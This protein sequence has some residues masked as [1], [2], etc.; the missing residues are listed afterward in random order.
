MIKQTICVLS[1]LVNATS[2]FA[3]DFET[4]HLVSLF[5]DSEMLSK[6]QYQSTILL[7]EN[8]NLSLVSSHYV[9]ET[10]DVRGRVAGETSRHGQ[11]EG[12][13]CTVL[14]ASIKDVFMLSC[15]ISQ[16]WRTWADRSYI[17][18]GINLDGE[19]ML[20]L[21]DNQLQCD[22]DK[23]SRATLGSSIKTVILGPYLYFVVKTTFVKNSG[24]SLVNSDTWF[25][26][27]RYSTYLVFQKE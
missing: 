13:S 15:K 17:E 18:T 23:L 1:L 20:H 11:S 16:E 8:Q 21:D 26:E 6:D 14:S 19:S 4:N 10:S 9:R 25:D 3:A 12:V 22:A 2:S 27:E 7:L 5:E 24:F